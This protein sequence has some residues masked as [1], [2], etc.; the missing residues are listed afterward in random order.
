MLTGRHVS[1]AEGY[2]L[3]FINEVVSG[4]NEEVVSAAKVWAG[5]ILKCGPLSIQAT[6][7][8][9]MQGTYHSSDMKDAFLA[10]NKLPA[11]GRL[12]QSDDFKEGPKAFSEKRAPNWKAR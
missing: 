6:K 2:D 5:M 8:A 4:G 7:E 12:Y 10:Q 9:A 11:I 1:A 3:G